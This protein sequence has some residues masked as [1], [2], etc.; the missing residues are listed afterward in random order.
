MNLGHEFGVSPRGFQIYAR[1]FGRQLPLDMMN[2]SR[3]A[4]A[5]RRNQRNVA[6]VLYGG[7]KFCRL[8][9]SVA[10]VFWPVVADNN[11]WIVLFHARII[12]KQ[13][14]NLQLLIA[15]FSQ[16][17]FRSELLATTVLSP[18]SFHLAHIVLAIGLK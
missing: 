13:P 8:L 3:L 16:R 1:E 10:E 4:V 6:V 18:T 11:K 15:N 12:S 5:S 14:S 7:D 9:L 17:C 2:Q